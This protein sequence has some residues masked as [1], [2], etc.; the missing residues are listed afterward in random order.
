MSSTPYFL[1]LDIPSRLRRAAWHRS[2]GRLDDAEETYRALLAQDSL[3]PEALCGLAAI[4]LTVG[5]HAVAL[6]LLERATIRRPDDAEIWNQIGAL[7]F[8]NADMAGARGAL[9]RALALTPSRAEHLYNLG[10]VARD[11]GMKPLALCWLRRAG[12]VEPLHP[13]ALSD[14]GV[15]LQTSGRPEAGAAVLR[16]LLALSPDRTIAW[17]NLGL[18]LAELGRPIDEDRAYR[19]AIVADPAYAAPRY[20]AGCL[21]LAERRYAAAVLHLATVL[22][23]DP[24]DARAWNNL[25]CTRR[26]QGLA[27]D[28]LCAFDRGYRITPEDR[29]L[30]SNLLMSLSAFDGRAADQAARNW[31]MRFPALHSRPRTGAAKDRRLRIGYLS[32]DFRRHSCAYFLAPLISAHDRTVAEIFAYADVAAPDPVTEELRSGMEH[33]RD[34]SILDDAALVECIAAD[35]LDILVDLAGHTAHN[36]LR[37]FASKP[38]PIQVGWLGYNATSGLTQIDWKIVDHWIRPRPD[39]EWFAERLWLLGRQAH[40]WRPPADAPDPNPVRAEPITFGSFNALHKLG[41]ATLA[42]WAEILTRV[43]GARLRL[44]GGAGADVTTGRRVLRIMADHGIADHRISIEG[45]NPSTAS[46]LDQYRHIDVALDPFPYNGTTTTCEALWMGVPVVTLAGHRMLSRIGISLLAAVGLDDLIAQDQRS[47]LEIAC[48]LA[49]DKERLAA[50][51][52]TLRATMAASPLRDETGFARAM[53]DAFMRMR[54][55]EE[56]PTA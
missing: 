44:K 43:P 42:L 29:D 13:F 37:V 56:A 36:R 52:A 15:L 6:S 47:Y 17:H 14:V 7:R 39:A 12:W 25:G 26:E 18:V 11:S 30:P 21:A 3:L 16:S 4:A 1:P 33:W 53:E 5:H 9:Y 41:D 10:I 40:C 38:V 31:G 24:A 8:G 32:P 45:W 34:V 46:H 23:L 20:N 27:T 50:L 49:A 51:H 48:R 35:D 55:G 28:A 2:A 19:R 22:A 54:R